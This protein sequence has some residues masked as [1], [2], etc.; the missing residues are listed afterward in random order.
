[1]SMLMLVTRTPR[2]LPPMGRGLRRWIKNPA[3][4]AVVRRLFNPPRIQSGPLLPT[5]GPESLKAAGVRGQDVI[6]AVRRLA[7]HDMVGPDVAMLL[8]SEVSMAA[9]FARRQNDPVIRRIDERREAMR[10]GPHI[11][12]DDSFRIDDGFDYARAFDREEKRRMRAIRMEVLRDA[13]ESAL[14]RM[15]EEHPDHYRERVLIGARQFNAAARARSTPRRT[16]AA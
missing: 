8:I 2:R 5:L 9:A 4:R 13:G 6:R 3:V 11:L 15:I 16:A 12:D 1:M 14:A 7:D 10:N